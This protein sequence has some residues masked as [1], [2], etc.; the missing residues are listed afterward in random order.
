[1]TDPAD[2]GGTEKR[3]QSRQQSTVEEKTHHRQQQGQGSFLQPADPEQ[4]AQQAI[5]HTGQ[6][7]APPRP[8][9]PDRNRQQ[10]D[11]D[12]DGEI[13]TA[14]LESHQPGERQEPEGVANQMTETGMTKR[15]R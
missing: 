11:T 2:A 14:A 8:D 15:G 3:N 1:M 5:D 4:V 6:A 7:M 12:P 9:Q 10:P 13:V